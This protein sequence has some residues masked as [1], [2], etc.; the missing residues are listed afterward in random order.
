MLK[1]ALEFIGFPLI[2]YIPEGIQL[3]VAQEAKEEPKLVTDY[4]WVQH[5]NIVAPM[6]KP[7]AEFVVVDFVERLQVEYEQ[8]S[9]F[10]E[11]E[12]SEIDESDCHLYN[13]VDFGEGFNEHYQ[14]DI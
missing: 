8:D 2:Q 10:S 6:V 1:E 7:T 12:Q 4:P 14:Q 3:L 9:D 11:R 5:S 13:N